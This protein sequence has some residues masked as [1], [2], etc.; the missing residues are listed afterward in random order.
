MEELRKDKQLGLQTVTP[1]A[2]ATGGGIL[3]NTSFG[4]IYSTLYFTHKKDTR[5]TVCKN[6]GRGDESKS[7]V[8]TQQFEISCQG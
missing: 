2:G 8:K 6:K 1:R 5:A 4:A 7:R 3:G